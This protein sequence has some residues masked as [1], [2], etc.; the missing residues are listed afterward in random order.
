M[1]GRGPRV[2]ER[3][4]GGLAG[5][6]KGRGPMAGGGGSPMGGERGV[7]RPRWKES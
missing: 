6:A 3:G 5:L 1:T 7:S 4:H 2:G